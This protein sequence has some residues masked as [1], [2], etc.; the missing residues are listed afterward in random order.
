[1]EIIDR[2]N[3]QIEILIEKYERAK[4]D[5]EVLEIKLARLKDEEDKIFRK[6][7]DMLF[8]IDSALNKEKINDE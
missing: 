3:H 8:N 2:L 4:I 5:K 6:S 7:Q 1:M